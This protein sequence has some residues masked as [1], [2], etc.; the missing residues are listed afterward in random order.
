MIR[1]LRNIWNSEFF[2]NVATLISGTS[3]AQAFA[4][5]IYIL[6]G[7][8]YTEEDFGVF[9]LYYPDLSLY[10]SVSCCF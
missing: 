4:V 8:I 2:R 3:V 5:I 1:A 10:L 7:R 9:G 6:L